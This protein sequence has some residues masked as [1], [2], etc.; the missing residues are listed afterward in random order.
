MSLPMSTK[1]AV[2]R[3]RAAIAKLCP[4]LLAIAVFFL[5][6]ASDYFFG[7]LAPNTLFR[8]ADDFA[9]AIVLG[10]VVLFYERRRRQHLNV[11]LGIIREMNHHVR[12][13]LQVI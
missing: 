13:A 6:V 11:Q 12:N 9:L 8:L 1:G 4:L 7:A 10:C 3:L 2:M 5:G